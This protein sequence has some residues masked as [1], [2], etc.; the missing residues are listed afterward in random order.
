MITRLSHS[1]QK[2]NPAAKVF[3]SFLVQDI[4]EIRSSSNYTYNNSLYPSEFD[5]RQ[6][7]LF[8]T[9][10]KWSFI[11]NGIRDF[12]LRRVNN[13]IYL[14]GQLAHFM[15]N[16]HPYCSWC[17]QF[18]LISIPKE[19][20]HHLFYTC[21]TTQY[22]LELYFGNLFSEGIDTEKI[23]FKGHNAENNFEIIYVNIE[24]ALF[25]FYMFQCKLSKKLPSISSISTS[26][27]FTKKQMILTSRFYSK[28]VGWIKSNKTG[29]VLD[30][31]RTLDLIIC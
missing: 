12:A 29:K 15:T 16:V 31:I 10:W 24:I 9:T 2:K 30:H 1:I 13:R 18:P 14:N 11:P 6:S 26:I 28:V 17:F 27:N 7:K 4:Y 3:R 20:Y 23:L 8:Y 22:I 25:T 19:T 5:E 21:P